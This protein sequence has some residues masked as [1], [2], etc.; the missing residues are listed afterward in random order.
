MKMK[1]TK[2]FDEIYCDDWWDWQVIPTKF[3]YKR[4]I[5]HMTDDDGA[6]TGYEDNKGRN[7]L[8]KINVW[9]CLYGYI[10]ILERQ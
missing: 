2:L 3:K 8:D 10:E 4:T 6:F 7:F 9:D 1:I 5:Y